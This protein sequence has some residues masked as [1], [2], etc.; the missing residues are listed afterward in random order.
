[1][2]KDHILNYSVIEEDTRM[3]V[4][5][6]VRLAQWIWIIEFIWKSRPADLLS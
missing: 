1:M 3:D 4:V 2:L 6:K 5:Y